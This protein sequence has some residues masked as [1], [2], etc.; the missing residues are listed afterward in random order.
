[1][2]REI[3]AWLIVCHGFVSV[4]SEPKTNISITIASIKDQSIWWSQLRGENAA[5]A[6]FSW[7]KKIHHSSQHTSPFT[8]VKHFGICNVNSFYGR[9]CTYIYTN[10][11]QESITLFAEEEISLILQRSNEN[12][13]TRFRKLFEEDNEAFQIWLE[14]NGSD[15]SWLIKTRRS[16]GERDMFTGCLVSLS[17][18]SFVK[19]THCAHTG[20]SLQ[21]GRGIKHIGPN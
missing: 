3:Q 14:R 11:G 1:M 6:I 2:L 12:N 20:V 18:F 17:L 21:I 4:T 10:G 7:T 13:C 16:A 15:Q 5:A 9:F 19:N 8:N